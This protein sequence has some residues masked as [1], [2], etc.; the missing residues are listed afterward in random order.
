MTHVRTLLRSIV[1]VIVSVAT[2]P[3]EAT[4]RIVTP[5]GTGPACQTCA[6]F[7]CPGHPDAGRCD[8]TRDS[9]NCSLI[10]R[11]HPCDEYRIR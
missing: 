7:P 3:T 2:L 4:A 5:L 11:P 10:N 1:L 6:P 8:T 9:R